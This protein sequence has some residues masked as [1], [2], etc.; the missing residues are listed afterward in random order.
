MYCTIHSDE[1]SL[2]RRKFLNL[3]NQVSKDV[4]NEKSGSFQSLMVSILIVSLCNKFASSEMRLMTF[5]TDYPNNRA[6]PDT[7]NKEDQEDHQIQ[8][9]TRRR[10]KSTLKPVKPFL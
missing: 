3:F 10:F 9:N 8:S 5:D 7:R 2:S 6:K 4:S 1:I